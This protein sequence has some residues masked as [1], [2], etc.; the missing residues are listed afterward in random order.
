MKKRIFI[1][2]L[3][4]FTLFSCKKKIEVVERD[5]FIKYA[6]NFSI[7]SFD[8]FYSNSKKG[9]AFGGKKAVIDVGA[10][11]VTYYFVPKS[12]DI[13]KNIELDGYVV[14]TPIERS[15]VMS[16][17]VLAPIL[18][19]G[20]PKTVV[21]LDGD[22]TTISYFKRG[23]NKKNIKLVSNGDTLNKELLVSLKAE[24]VFI[25]GLEEKFSS[26]KKLYENLKVTPIFIT[27]WKESSPLGRAE[28]M[29]FIALF[30]ENFNM[31]ENLFLN[32]ENSYNKMKKFRYKGDDN[33]VLLNF[34]EYKNSVWLLPGRDS[35]IGNIVKDAGGELVFSSKGSEAKYFDLETIF[36]NCREADVWVINSYID[37]SNF[38]ETA[39]IRE[40]R[41]ENFPPYYSSKVYIN[42]RLK[43]DNGSNGYFDYYA[44]SPDKVLEDMIN[45]L[46]K[47]GL[48]DFNF[49][50]QQFRSDT[51]F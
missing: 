17:S 40:P 18:S 36:K 27:D 7:S 15:I 10:K 50:T 46:N 35:Y 39:L 6:D 21:G 38:F 37:F 44:I 4:L 26:D 20:E 45:I 16:R 48:K 30:Y 22:Y 2:L 51:D 29:K 5:S 42:N 33:K 9:F 34:P 25:L 13:P 19:V 3:I 14:R 24:V 43:Q 28:W 49:Y 12:M 23:I 47:S 41:L 1:L 31:A 11:S 32:I 8:V